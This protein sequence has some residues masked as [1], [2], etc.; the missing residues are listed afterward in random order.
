MV[1][2]YLF[3]MKTYIN[4][5]NVSTKLSSS[6]SAKLVY[7]YRWCYQNRYTEKIPLELVKYNIFQAGAHTIKICAQFN[8]NTKEGK[9]S[10]HLVVINKIR[11]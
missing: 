6:S 7:N 9:L 8:F 5:R 10:E 1:S 4:K 2:E 3:Q 11:K